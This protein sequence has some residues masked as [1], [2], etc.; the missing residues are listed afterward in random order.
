MSKL[1]TLSLYFQQIRLSPEDWPRHVFAAIAETEAFAR[2]PNFPQSATLAQHRLGHGAGEDFASARIRATGELV[3]IASCC[4]WGD[5]TLVTAP[6]T[7]LSNLVYSPAELCGFSVD[8]TANRIIWNAEIEGVDWIPATTDP[9]H[10]IDWMKAQCLFT[11]NTIFVP[12]DY[13][14]IG[15]RSPGD[16]EACAV[17][18]TNGCA[19]GETREDASLR[20]LF[21]LIERDAT[22]QWWY[23]QHDVRVLDQADLPIGSSIADHL[24]RHGRHLMLLDLTTDIGIPTVAALAMDASGGY[25]GAGFATRANL[26]SAV[27][28]AVT[29]LMQ[30]ELRIA[31]ARSSLVA[32]AQLAKWFR[33]VRFDRTVPFRKRPQNESLF[34]ANVDVSLDTCIARLEAKRCRVGMLDFTRS[35]FAVPVM[36]AVSPDLCHWKPRFGRARLSGSVNSEHVGAIGRPDRPDICLL[37]I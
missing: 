19:A 28:A 26:H 27:R 3:E 15:R 21:E 32:D 31:S 17:A 37:R 33:D 10:P 13:V 4:G 16:L 22:G 25:L 9:T 18:D 35:E 29:E 6:Q 1:D 2:W 24:D 23:G 7:D 30:M 14:L 11:G 34:H 36:R 12:A 8:Q 20:A 5:E